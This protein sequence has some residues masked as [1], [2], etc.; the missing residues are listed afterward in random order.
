MRAIQRILQS[1]LL[2]LYIAHVDAFWRMVC[3]TIQT[4]RIDPI[5]NPGAISGHAHTVAGPLS[6]SRCDRLIDPTDC[7][8]Q[9]STPHP[10]SRAIKPRTAHHAQYN[11]IRA[12]TGLRNF[13]T[14]IEM[15]RTHTFL[16]TGLLSTTWVEAQIAPTSSPSHPGSGCF[17]ET[18]VYEPMMRTRRHT[19]IRTLLPIALALRASM[20]PDQCRRPHTWL[21]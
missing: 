6:E 20:F 2:C 8:S 21:A 4:G 3:G 14:D 19:K 17:P 9:T 11:K 1:A 12:R 18:M 7:S 15:A 10:H 13:T 5:V 16:M